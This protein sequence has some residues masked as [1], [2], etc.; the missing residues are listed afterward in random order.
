[1]HIELPG[2]T[3]GSV[4][5]L[6]KQ[7]GLLRPLLSACTSLAGA[8]E[9]EKIFCDA[10]VPYWRRAPAPDMAHLTQ[11]LKAISIAMCEQNRL[12]VQ[13][14]RENQRRAVHQVPRYVHAGASHSEGAEGN[15]T[16][17]S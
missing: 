11:A 12:L 1:M 7:K 13:L 8:S 15:N 4:P 6:L 17:V 9:I 2:F 14:E 5:T 10:N 16:R 3:H